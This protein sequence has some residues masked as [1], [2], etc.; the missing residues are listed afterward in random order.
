MLTKDQKALKNAYIDEAISESFNES[1]RKHFNGKIDRVVEMHD[2]R[3]IAIEKP[4]ISKE[5]C[6]GWHSTMPG[7]DYEE[8]NAMAC[9]AR[10]S[11]EYFIKENMRQIDSE[12]EELA[13][14]RSRWTPKTGIHYCG[15]PEDSKICYLKWWDLFDD[16]GHDRKETDQDV[17]EEDM[18]KILSAYIETR[19]D[20]QKRLDTYLKRY[21]TKHVR[22]WTYWADA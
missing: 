14:P 18:E 7:S 12:I 21:G 22:A 13:R 8:A 6:F 5:F 1:M 20:F 19:K 10:E 15:A 11:E 4:S 2:G 9:Y 17:T 16:M 3:M